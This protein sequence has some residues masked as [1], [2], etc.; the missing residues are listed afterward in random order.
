MDNSSDDFSGIQ[1]LITRYEAMVEKHPSLY[2]D[3]LEFFKIYYYYLE[4]DRRQEAKAVIEKACNLHP[5]QLELL[6][7]YIDELLDEHRVKEA[8]DVAFREDLEESEELLLVQGEILLLMDKAESAGELFLKAAKMVDY[9]I[10]TLVE[11]LSC[12][13]GTIYVSQAEP[14]V[15]LV[16]QQ[17]SFEQLILVDK[18]LRSMLCNYY[19]LE[20]RYEK[21]IEYSRIGV[22][23]EPYSS[24]AWADLAKAL[25]FGQCYSEAMEAA[26]FALAI[27]PDSDSLFQLKLSILKETSTEREIHSFFLKRIREDQKSTRPKLQLIAYYFD[28]GKYKLVSIYG[29]EF[30]AFTTFTQEERVK[31]LITLSLSALGVENEKVAHQYALLAMNCA[32]KSHQPLMHYGQCWLFF[33]RPNQELAENFFKLALTHALPEKRV[34]C[35]FEIAS[36][37][38]EAKRYS[39][40]ISYF[41]KA[42]LEEGGCSLKVQIYLIYS[43]FCEKRIE[44]LVASLKSLRK[45]Y[46]NAYMHINVLLLEIGSETVADGI[47]EIQKEIEKDLLDEEA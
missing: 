20:K 23:Q 6:F 37:Y 34:D 42:I 26:D 5:T 16:E 9:D 10:E 46:T 11:I 3:S 41:D 33:E 35:L 18:Q 45:N 21:N 28:L 36:S 7:C 32:P 2:F 15:K 13:S 31:L 12:Y 29:K 1:E 4:N 38:F 39:E 43:Y 14:F 24:A 47:C 25:V 27:E 40:S 30:L 19:L 44:E 8:F 22:E 17:D